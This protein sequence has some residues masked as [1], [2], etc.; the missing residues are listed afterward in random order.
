ME[1]NLKTGKKNFLAA[2]GTISLMSMAPMEVMG[3]NPDC[4]VY[5]L[6]SIKEKDGL[7]HVE[8]YDPVEKCKYTIKDDDGVATMSAV[9]IGM[10]EDFRRGKVS[11]DNDE[12]DNNVKGGSDKSG[13][14]EKGGSSKSR[15]AQK[16]SLKV[17]TYIPM[18]KASI[19][20]AKKYAKDNP[21][22]KGGPSDFEKKFLSMEDTL[23]DVM[24]SGRITRE[25][26]EKLAPAMGSLYNNVGYDRDKQCIVKKDSNKG[27]GS[28]GGSDK[29]GGSEETW[30]DI[31]TTRKNL[32]SVMSSIR[33]TQASFDLDDKDKVC[34]LQVDATESEFI[35]EQKTDKSGS[36]KSGGQVR[37]Q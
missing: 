15:V 23:K 26:Y 30:G 18:I 5:Q 32:T 36:S 28:K 8:L 14:S 29:G 37:K 16:G 9:M 33:G 4:G 21:S 12:D 17:N 27:G 2:F 6:N 25:Q 10:K 1:E 22:S 35:G 34:P 19:A 11:D 13:S 7:L 20:Q 3:Q 24:L 31:S